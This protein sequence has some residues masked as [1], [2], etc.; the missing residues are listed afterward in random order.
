MGLVLGGVFVDSVG[1]RYGYYIGAILTFVISIVLLFS[2]PS[3]PSSGEQSFA[4]TLQRMKADIDWIGC[5]LLSTSLGLFS[6][7]FAILASGASSFLK[8]IPIVLLPLFGFHVKRQERLNKPAIIPLSIL[9][10]RVFTTLC[11]SVF[12]IWGSFNSV[13]FFLTLFFQSNSVSFR[14]PDLASISA[15]GCHWRLDEHPNRLGLSNTFELTIWC[16]TLRPSQRFLR[17]SWQSQTPNG[18]TGHA[19]SSPLPSAQSPPT[20]SSQSPI[21]SSP[22]SFHH[23]CTALQV[24]F[25]TRSP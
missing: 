14:H 8:L 9:G 13:Q 1:W 17:S 10:N 18:I 23:I 16:F 6:Y 19:L 22:P 5:T 2:I 12:L 24:G 21:F 25:S 3:D 4:A 15:N 20:C 7:V 11:I